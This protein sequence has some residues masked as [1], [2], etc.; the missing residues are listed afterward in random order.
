MP[1]P[2]PG[3]AAGRGW[4]HGGG[5][6]A[7][8]ALPLAFL[9]IVFAYPLSLV[10]VEAFTDRGPYRGV[11]FTLQ[12]VAGV[13]SDPYV[14]RLLA[15]TARQALLSALMSLAIGLP[16][17]YLFVRYDFPGKSAL[18]SVVLVPFVLPAVTVALGFILVFGNNGVLNRTLE[19][20]FGFRIPVLYSLQGIVLA[21]A[22]YNAPLVVRTVHATWESVDPSYQ[23]SARALGAGRL[24][25]FAT[26][27]LPM[28]APGVVTGT[29]LAFV[30]SFMSFAIVLALGGARLATLEVEIFTQVRVLLDYAT[31][32]ALALVE[33]VLS[34]LLTYLY[35]RAEASLR[36][37][38]LPVRR[39][40][41]VPLRLSWRHAPLLVLGAL[42]AAFFASPLVAVL[43]D[44][45]THGAG[46]RFTLRWFRAVLAPDYEALA[47]DSPLRAVWNSLRFGVATVGL[48]VPLGLLASLFLRGSRAGRRWRELFEV[49]AV[50][51]LGVSGVALGFGLL[52]ATLRPPLA[53]AGAAWAIVAVHALLALPFVIRTIRPALDALHPSLAES[54]R[55]L[56]ASRWRALREVELPLVGR[57]LLLGAAL[58]FSISFSEMTATIVLAPPGLSTMPLTVYHLL[59]A[60]SFGGASAMAVLLILVTGTSF[61]LLERFG[62]GRR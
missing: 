4:G 13:L 10:F 1:G 41:T 22:F 58:A 44:A 20:L 16:V 25:A 48:A 17:A 26:V 33:T 46:G 54:A 27:T 2:L 38:W 59:A 62:G 36:T 14:H 31:G 40:P 45:L 32:A 39:Q 5:D 55:S 61:V 43:W 51:P 52:R 12:H 3:R 24:R 19:A 42:A 57:S 60:R 34:L 9:L 37:R 30:F 15:F 35:L 53:G 23:E 8:A 29:L 56:G 11:A 49:M 47:G 21:H 50:A 28:I 18:R 6:L 7:L